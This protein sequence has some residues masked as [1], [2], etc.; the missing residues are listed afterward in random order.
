MRK[1]R[2]AETAWRFFGRRPRTI[3]PTSTVRRTIPA[4]KIIVFRFGADD[5]EI[6]AF[7]ARNFTS[8]ESPALTTPID[9]NNFT[10]I[11]QKWRSEVRPPRRTQI[12]CRADRAK[13]LRVWFLESVKWRMGN[14]MSKVWE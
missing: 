1:L 9:R 5:A 6:K 4:D 8:G 2:Q 11:Y 10:F 14:E 13:G 3:R 7:I 12:P